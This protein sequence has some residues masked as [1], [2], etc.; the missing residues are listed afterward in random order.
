MKKVVHVF[1]V[2]MSIIFLED[3]YAKLK[4]RGYELIVIC[5]DG[6][7]IRY[8]EELGNLKFY[9]VN[10]S[11]GISPFRDLI[12]LIKIITILF[13]EK[14]SIVHGHTPKGGFLAML[15]AKFINVKNRPYHLHGLKFPGETGIRK[16]IIRKMEKVTISLST[17][18]YSV[19]RSLREYAIQEGLGT[20]EKLKVILNGSVKGIDIR[21]SQA[22]IDNGSDYYK[23]ILNVKEYNCI[24]G[25]IGRVTEEKGIVEFMS[26]IKRLLTQGYNIGIILC[27]PNEIIFQENRKQFSEFIQLDN[28]QYYGKVNNPLEYMIC[29]D[30]FA[31]P[32]YREGFGLVNIEANSVGVPVITT[33]I[34]GCLDSIEDNITGIAIKSKDEKTLYSALKKLIDNPSL[35]K[36]MGGSGLKRVRELY[37]RNEIWDMLIYEYDRMIEEKTVN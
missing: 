14:P 25:Y 31:L 15:A 20:K 35:R 13:K 34:I 9:P 6:D 19:S 11:R 16:K 21:K 8:Q 17:E 36:K 10:I 18:V 22:I 29:C 5:S 3:L 32:T 1:T 4:E 27:G 2:S 24:I 28:V 7:E 37:D 12:A 33:N 23:K 26:A 30:I